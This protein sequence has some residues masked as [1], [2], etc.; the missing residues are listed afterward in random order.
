[1]HFQFVDFNR[2]KSKHYW[3]QCYEKITYPQKNVIEI[4]RLYHHMYENNK[5]IIPIPQE[6]IFDYKKL[7]IDILS[8]CKQDML[9]WDKQVLDYFDQ[10]GTDLFRHLNIWDADWGNIAQKWRYPCP[11][12]YKD[13]RKIWEKAINIWLK[14]TQNY[15]SNIWIQRIDRLFK[16]IYH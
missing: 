7:D 15:Q 11:Q 4:F 16:L 1:M 14:K 9:Y 3:Y 2:M 6:W 13:P 12:K 8:V 5:A 10:Y